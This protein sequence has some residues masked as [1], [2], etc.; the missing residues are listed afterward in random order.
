MKIFDFKNPRHLEILRE[1]LHRVK[2]LMIESSYNEDKIWAAMTPDERWDA[3]ASTHDDEGPDL[4]DE[5]AD[6]IWDK[7]PDR[8]TDLIDMSRYK[9][10]RFDRQFGEPLWRGIKTIRDI[11]YKNDPDYEKIKTAIQKL[12]DEYCKNIG[13]EFDNLTSK[14]AMELNVKVQR[15]TSQLKPKPGMSTGSSN[16]N[17]YDMPGGQPSRGYMGAKWTGD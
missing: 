11:N 2:M 6:E 16:I 14:Q 5:Y 8:I 12:I 3:I 1:E 4:A 17:P 10:A 9:L 7:V 13:R 15:L